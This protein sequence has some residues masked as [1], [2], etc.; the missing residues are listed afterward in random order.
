MKGKMTEPRSFIRLRD[1]LKKEIIYRLT[2]LGN[3][4]EDTLLGFR[5]A[6]L[7]TP[8]IHRSP[9]IADLKEYYGGQTLCLCYLGPSLEKNV[10]LLKNIQNNCVI[11]ACD[12]VLFHLLEKGIIPHVVTT[13]ERPYDSYTAW[14][15]RVL[16]KV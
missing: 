16:E 15:P 5:H 14:L 8:R 2:M 10:H 7:N 11:V 1:T 3:S 9:R 12:T 4:P 13:I 6:T